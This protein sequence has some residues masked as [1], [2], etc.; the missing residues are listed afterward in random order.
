MFGSME[1]LI[2]SNEEMFQQV[3][4]LLSQGK[5]VTIPVK[6]YSML[7]LIVGERDLVELE[8]SPQ[9]K[10]GDIVLFNLRGRWIMHRILHF[11]SNGNAVIR[12]DGV[13]K[14]CEICPP[15]AI[16]G[17]AVGILRKGKHR[18]DPYTPPRMALYRAWEILRP[19]RRYILFIFRHLPW[20]RK[21]FKVQ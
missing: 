15:S 21:Y 17:R 10:T 2:V 4:G 1:K 8:S 20:N 6:G 9:Y 7:P 13:V 5:K 16:S 12:G 19:L 18:F 3:A 11:D 14:G